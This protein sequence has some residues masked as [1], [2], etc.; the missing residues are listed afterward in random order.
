MITKLVRIEN[1]RYF[2]S[3]GYDKTLAFWSA[4]KGDCIY[5]QASKHSNTV[6]DLIRMEDKLVTTSHDGTIKIF[7]IRF[8]E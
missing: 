5:G 7:L 2:F 1:G 8:R 6:T 4:N 3:S